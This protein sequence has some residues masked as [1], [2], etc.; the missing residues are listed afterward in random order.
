MLIPA[1]NVGIGT[2]TPIAPLEVRAGTN[3]DFYVFGPLGL[4]SGI[5]LGAVNDAD[6]ASV[7]M[8]LYASQFYFA[9]GNVTI[10][11]T[12]QQSG[13][14]LTISGSGYASGG[15]W[16]PSDGRLKDHVAT[17]TDGL[18]LVEQLRPVRYSWLPAEKRTVGKN[19][20][21]GTDRSQI[22]FIA[23]EVEKVVPEAVNAPAKGST[24]TYA[25]N[26]SALIPVLTKAIQEQ[27]DE[28]KRAQAEIAAQT[29][30]LGAQQAKIERLEALVAKTG[31]KT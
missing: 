2:T 31:P 3:E 27:E 9:G 28:I 24:D 5:A 14:A 23:Q 26:E 18:A 30:A 8:E 19:L 6:A 17:V 20:K 13:Y 11:T 10:G 22:G 29:S 15:T 4:S 1:G 21:L 12:T 16:D 25:M 7:P